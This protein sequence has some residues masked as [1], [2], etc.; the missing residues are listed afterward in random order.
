MP[1]CLPCMAIAAGGSPVAVPVAGAIAIAGPIVDRKRHREGVAVVSGMIESRRVARVGV[2]GAGAAVAGSGKSASVASAAPT[3]V[4]MVTSQ[5]DAIANVKAYIVANSPA[6]DLSTTSWRQVWEMRFGKVASVDQAAI[7]AF[8]KDAGA[9]APMLVAFLGDGCAVTAS[10]FMSALNTKIGKPADNASVS[11]ADLAL[12]MDLPA[13]AIFPTEPTPAPP[14]FMVSP[15]LLAKHLPAPPVPLPPVVVEPSEAES[16]IA[17][18]FRSRVPPAW[19]CY[20]VEAWSAGTASLVGGARVGAAPAA[21]AKRYV[22]VRGAPWEITTDGDQIIA[23]SAAYRASKRTG[24]AGGDLGAML[25]T[26]DA[27][28]A[29]A[30]NHKRVE[31]ASTDEGASAEGVLT[32]ADKSEWTAF[33]FKQQTDSEPDGQTGYYAER[34]GAL[35]GPSYIG[36]SD[37]KSIVNRYLDRLAESKGT[38]TFSKGDAASRVDDA[39]TAVPMSPP[40]NTSIARWVILP[41]LVGGAVGGLVAGLTGLVIG[42][43]AAGIGGAVVRRQ[44]AA[45]VPS[46]G[47][48]IDE[49]QYQDVAGKIWKISMIGGA[50]SATSPAYSTSIGA[51]VSE[52]GRESLPGRIDTYVANLSP[53]VAGASVS[54]CGC[55]VKPKADRTGDVSASAPSAAAP[56]DHGG[57]S[58]YDLHHADASRH[59]AWGELLL[60]A[61]HISNDPCGDC[62]NK[63]LGQAIFLLKEARTLKEGDL[64]DTSMAADLQAMQP[65]IGTKLEEVVAIRRRIGERLGIGHARPA[66]EHAHD[67]HDHA[68]GPAHD[69]AAE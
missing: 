66:G 25:E 37:L 41:A 39:P 2:S 13:E 8:L 55:E 65:E 1:I 29:D 27:F 14:V 32:D 59:K 43:V 3:R 69:H 15:G 12:F 45:T 42:G 62:M 50:W 26:I 17:R 20:R 48:W 53:Q 23:Q 30:V 18:Q 51:A 60:L 64:E 4:G 40:L 57:S 9:C 21:H 61:D 54:G 68:H 16:E 28:V 5:D 24:S 31:H 58:P 6:H 22:D 38:S 67:H 63:H 35:V 46:H 33:Y 7:G 34:Y 52:G 49:T 11:F 47:Q 56:H 19:I 44:N 36:T 10:M